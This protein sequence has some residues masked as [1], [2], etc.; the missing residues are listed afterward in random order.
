[1]EDKENQAG[2]STD[3]KEINLGDVLPELSLMN[4]KD[5]A[6]DV[7]KLAGEKGLV[8]FLVPKADTRE[9]HTSH[10]HLHLL[11]HALQLDALSKRVISGIN[12][13]NSKR[14]AI[15]CTA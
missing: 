6:V 11:I 13:P 14:S 4:E 12:M 15:T 8:M 9:S 3:V 10:P 5:Q 2:S 7:G 1:M